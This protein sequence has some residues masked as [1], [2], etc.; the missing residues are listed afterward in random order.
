MDEDLG[1]L[2]TADLAEERAARK[3]ADK[4]VRAANARLA[5]FE[6]ASENSSPEDPAEIEAVT[7][8]RDSAVAALLRHQVRVEKKLPAESLE[9]L[10]G[11]TREELEE[12]AEAMAAVLALSRPPAPIVPSEGTAPDRVNSPDLQARRILIGGNSFY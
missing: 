5:E 1:G 7:A 4:A 10:T 3:E 6:S 12:Q 11:G 8:E 9:F 2:T